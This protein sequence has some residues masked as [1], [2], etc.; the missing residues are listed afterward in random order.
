MRVC[1]C[2]HI[3]ANVRTYSQGSTLTIK[4]KSVMAGE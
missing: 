3:T 1:V 2:L 4:V